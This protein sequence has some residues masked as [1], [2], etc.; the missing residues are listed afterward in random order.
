MKKLLA[1][2]LALMMV[3]TLAV[4]L[5]A[6]ADELEEIT[7]LYPG[8]ETDAFS[9]FINGAFAQKVKEDLN[10]KVNFRFL[11]WDSYWDQKK[12]LLA[13]NEPIDLYW[14]GLPDLSSMVNNKEA[15]PLD[16]LIAKAWPEYM[17]DV[18]PET[19]MNG[20]KINGVQYGIPSAYAPSSAMFQFV[21]LRQDLLEQVGMTE[22]KTAEDLREYAERVQDQ[23]PGFRGPGDIIFKP[24]TRYFADEQYFWVA[25][26]DLVV[27]GED[28]HKAYSY[29]HTDAFKK[30]A[31]FNREMFLDGLY[32]DEL[33]IKYNERESRVQTGLYLWVEGSLA[34]DLEIGNKVKTA[35][36][37]AVMGNYLLAPEKPRYVNTA[38]G[39]VL[40]VPY[41]AKNPEGAMKFLAWL[42]GS[43]DNY[44]FCLYGEKG[45]DWDLDENGG[46]QLISETAAGEG[47][48]YE[49]MFRNANYQVF[50]SDVSKEYIENYLNWDKDA[51]VSAMFGFNFSDE[52]VQLIQTSCAEAWKKLAPI[53]YGYVDFDENY[54]AAIAELEAA[55]INEYVDEVNR[56]LDEFLAKK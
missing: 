6:Q 1:V 23:L 17:K 16:D 14:D 24:L 13:A 47:F 38:G 21:C 52:K 51:Q 53:L 15:Q 8:E 48:F 55:G 49:W 19:Q 25:Y 33:A 41:S 32:Q 10:M 30:V 26:Q 34:K 20:G 36:P 42:W 29:A 11:S 22:V 44:L 37:N 43:Q 45:K 54:P 46:L 4:P 12:I 35:D 39:E 50:P 31:Q 40:C 7:I 18:L 3:L 28:T 9:E 56:Q 5:M 27:F 2:V